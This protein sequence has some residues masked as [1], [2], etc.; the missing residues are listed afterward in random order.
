MSS[1]ACA[2][3]EDGGPVLAAFM[4]VGLTST[5]VHL[6]LVCKSH[7]GGCG[8]AQAQGYSFGQSHC[9]A[10]ACSIAIVTVASR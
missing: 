5:F 6:W 4:L 1:P 3:F 9:R 8:E 10:I 7:S 2:V